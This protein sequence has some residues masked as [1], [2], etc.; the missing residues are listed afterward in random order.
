MC[1]LLRAIGVQGLV[2]PIT[3]V[4]DNARYQRNATVQG[5]G[6]ATSGPSQC[7]PRIPQKSLAA[8]SFQTFEND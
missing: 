3:L 8:L 7:G 4:L 1:E 2:G 5:F 6:G